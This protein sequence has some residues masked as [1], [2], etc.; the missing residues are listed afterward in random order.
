MGVEPLWTVEEV[1]QYLRL[2]PDTVRVMA[3]RGRL[4]GVRVGRVWRFSKERLDASL[5]V[6]R[7]A[8]G[9]GSLAQP[10]EDA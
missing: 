4:P 7:P 9:V 1:A 5:G 2:D 3:R 6:A 8:A 10:V